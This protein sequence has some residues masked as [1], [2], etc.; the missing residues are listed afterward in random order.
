[1]EKL[2]S[3]LLSGTVCKFCLGSIALFLWKS[4]NFESISRAAGIAFKFLVILSG[5]GITLTIAS[6][7]LN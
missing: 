4:G 1:M 3:F 2:T 7:Y 5:L 6:A